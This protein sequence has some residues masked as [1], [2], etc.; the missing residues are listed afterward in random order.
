M[1]LSLASANMTTD[2]TTFLNN[3]LQTN[4]PQELAQRVGYTPAFGGIRPMPTPG[5][6]EWT[7][8]YQAGQALPNWAI[9]KGALRP[10]RFISDNLG[11][12]HMRSGLAGAALG[13]ML[14]AG[15]SL[16]TGAPVGRGA[17]T[18]AGMGAT[19]MLLASLYAQNRLNRTNF[20]QVPP[21]P[22]PWKK[23]A[24]Y[25]MSNDSQDLQQKLISDPSMSMMDKNTLLQYV[26]KLSSQQQAELSHLIGG[27]L[28]AGV[29]V[30]IAR[31]LLH[32]GV[33]GSALMGIIGGAVGNQWATPRNAF[34]Q[35]QDSSRDPFGQPRFV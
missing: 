18:G 27:A 13:G 34:G 5:S 12:S 11:T 32:L 7:F 4:S 6:R 17:A 21:D 9:N 35:G 29:G 22:E 24:F 30:L 25:A 33:G 15:S 1:A 14:G 31:Y 26:Q 10:L 2:A 20:R 23:S 3:Q 8:G 28:G 16:L 19:A